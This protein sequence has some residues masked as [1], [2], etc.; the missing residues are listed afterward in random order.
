MRRRII[1]RFTRATT[2][3]ALPP[4]ELLANIQ[5]T[6]YVR[7]YLDVGRRSARSVV[8]ELA[9]A[10]FGETQPLNALDFGCGSAR[11]LRHVA[12]LTSWTLHGC[13]ID[14][15]AIDWAARTFPD[16]SFQVNDPEPP[17]R[18]NDT[19]FDIVYAI[20]L[21]TH[22]SEEMQQKWIAEL[23]RIVRPGGAIVISSMGPSV[24]AN[25]PSYATPENIR[26]LHERGSL[27]ISKPGEFN[28]SAAFHSLRGLTRLGGDALQLL[29]W[30]EN[31]LDGFQDLAL[32]RKRD[33]I[34]RLP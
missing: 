14:R 8:S 4:P 10:G 30:R 32:F 3:P 29:A 9:A 7:E 18:F 5:M 27:F 31:G 13:D 21:F 33:S 34:I 11:A 6:P 25:F 1:D 2:S 26:T 28:A 24:I 23:Q 17:L 15:P 19:T 20:S 16:A 22:F 12:A